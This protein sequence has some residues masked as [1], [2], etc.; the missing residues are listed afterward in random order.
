M[1][2]RPQKVT[3][4]TDVAQDKTEFDENSVASITPMMQQYLDVKK[5]YNDY[6][7]FYRM[8]DFLSFSMMMLSP[9]ARLWT[10]F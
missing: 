7:L 6:L 9:P 5:R 2:T 3:R 8:G 1:N 10:L 4:Q